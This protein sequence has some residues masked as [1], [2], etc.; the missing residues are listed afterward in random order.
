MSAPLTK[1]RT[2]AFDPHQMPSYSLIYSI[3][4]VIIKITLTLRDF[5]KLRKTPLRDYYD[6]NATGGRSRVGLLRRRRRG[7]EEG[8]RRTTTIPS[9]TLRSSMSKTMSNAKSPRGNR[10][11]RRRRRRRRCRRRRRRR[12]RRLRSTTP[13]RAPTP[14]R[15]RRSRGAGCDRC[16]WERRQE[17]KDGEFF[18][19]DYVS[20]IYIYIYLDL[21]L[22]H[23]RCHLR[24][25]SLPIHRPYLNFLPRHQC[26]C[27]HRHFDL[28]MRW[29]M[30]G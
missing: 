2:Q 14:S 21:T 6:D 23:S 29:G 8:R 15:R 19:Y 1:F 28:G 12:L 24:Q 11:C 16:E 17:G 26:Q 10:R 20:P 3:N 30:D 25:H 9:S 18:Y 13:T 27:P 4:G 7:E 22:I 5:D